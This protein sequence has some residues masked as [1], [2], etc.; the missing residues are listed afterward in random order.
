L[1]RYALCN[2]YRVWSSFQQAIALLRQRCGIAALWEHIMGL[3]VILIVGGL[4][5]WLASKVMGTDPQQGIILNVVVG[6][7]GALI[8]GLLLSPV[9]G[10]APIT[11]GNL[12]VRS[13]V[14]SFLGSIILLGIVNLLRRGAVR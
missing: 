12:D 8:G 7:V 5:G 6:I 3:I 4:L 10:G 9:L 13:L 2:A 11:S 1:P 14:I